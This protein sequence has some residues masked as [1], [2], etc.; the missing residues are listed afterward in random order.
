MIIGMCYVVPCI[1][2]IIWQARTIYKFKKRWLLT[3]CTL[4]TVGEFISEIIKLSNQYPDHV[5]RQSAI[6][7]IDSIDNFFIKANKKLNDSIGDRT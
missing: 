4:N 2:I 3:Q 6:N 5:R 7:T 1:V